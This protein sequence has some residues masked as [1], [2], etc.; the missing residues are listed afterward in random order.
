MARAVK[1]LIH[2]GGK[3]WKLRF[4]ATLGQCAD[5]VTHYIQSRV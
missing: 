3:V 2:I 1:P 4:V 5:K